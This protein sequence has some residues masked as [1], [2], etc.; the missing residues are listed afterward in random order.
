MVS[1]VT[2]TGTVNN[3]NKTQSQS[4][5]LAEDFTQFLTLLTTQ[6]QN[7]DPLSPMD[8][9]EFTNQLVQFSQVEQS[10]NTNQKLDDLL[11][12]QL[13]SISSVALG[14]VGMDIS[15]V[16]GEM[17]HETGTESKVN[18]VLSETATLSKINIY[19]E[20]GEIVRTMD[21]PKTTG[22]HTVVWDGKDNNGNVV[23]TGTY[24]IKIDALNKENKSIAVSPV[25]SGNV[26]GIESQNGVVYLLVGDRAVSLGSVIQASNKPATTPTPPVTEE[27]A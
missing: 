9:T 20:K 21:A 7:Q 6:L 10:I 16:S 22:A 3:A 25:V 23:E 13:G 2:V 11:S 27:P 1:D 5:K 8:S 15:Y 4:I 12:L 19:N 26:R 17:Y 14:Y 24:G 18:F